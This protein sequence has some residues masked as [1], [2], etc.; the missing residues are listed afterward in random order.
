VQAGTQFSVTA[1][2]MDGAGG[3][4]T[5]LP[6]NAF[7]LSGFT[8]DAPTVTGSTLSS[9]C[10]APGLI[11]QNPQSLMLE[12]DNTSVVSEAITLVPGD[13]DA[14]QSSFSLNPDAS[15]PMT[16]IGADGSNTISATFTGRDRFGNPAASAS[17]TILAA[18]GRVNGSA[19]TSVT[20]NGTGQATV[21][22]RTP[23][24]FNALGDTLTAQFGGTDVATASIALKPAIT[25][26]TIVASDGMTSRT[27][28]DNPAQGIPV[29][30]TLS[31]G[32]GFV[33]GINVGFNVISG[34][35]MLGAVT[36]AGNGVYNARLFSTVAGD[37]T[38]GVQ[39][40]ITGGNLES[41]AGVTANFSFTPEDTIHV[42]NTQNSIVAPVAI[43]ATQSD[44][45]SVTP[46][47]RFDNTTTNATAVAMT[48]TLGGSRGTLGT[49]VKNAD[50]S[51]TANY[52]ANLVGNIQIT[53]RA[54]SV[55]SSN[56]LIDTLAI[57]LV[58]AVATVTVT[59]QEQF[60][61]SSGTNLITVVIRDNQN[62]VIPGDL[63][64]FITVSPSNGITGAVTKVG[65][66]YQTTYT[67][68][69][70]GT[71]VTVTATV[72]QGMAAPVSGNVTFNVADTTDFNYTVGADAK[73]IDIIAMVDNSGDFTANLNLIR[74]RMLDVI[75]EVNRDAT[76]DWRLSIA[77]L[78]YWPNYSNGY[79]LPDASG[80]QF[81]DRN[82]VDKSGWVNAVLGSVNA[83]S[84]IEDPTMVMEAV[85]DEFTKV[86]GLNN[87]V[88]R[89]NSHKFFISMTD[90]APLSTR[91]DTVPK[92]ATHIRDVILP[93]HPLKYDNTRTIT[94]GAIV[95]AGAMADH[96]LLADET[97]GGFVVQLD[98]ANIG[99]GLSITGQQIYQNNNRVYF[100]ERVVRVLSVTLNGV[101][102][103]GWTLDS[104]GMFIE[105]PA[106]LGTGDLMARTITAASVQ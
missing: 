105:F 83:L 44:S 80:A 17:V 98:T 29:R 3:D 18:M 27:V 78:T 20:L 81:I 47:D 85:M 97:N 64:S 34:N 5:G 39:V 10:T 41:V 100:S 24:T 8:C 33:D 30:V 40:G 7:T 101:V 22:Y 25:S 50:G 38:L 45:I 59:A 55:L 76:V 35:A 4:V 92:M 95:A 82:T 77:T 61:P 79:L 91:F 16:A 32:G 28:T 89:T 73:T 104:S 14:G 106:G 94:Y 1:A 75:A 58:P 2:L 96:Q 72:D 103:S 67:A 90:S 6:G 69:N 102:Q 37:V 9:N 62:Q 74:Q 93:M 60:V 12:F 53:I 54:T 23:N 68:P 99:N 36:A 26:A 87:N 65:N 70:G 66:D 43:F 56:V 86:N 84:P 21:T 63:T 48:V 31:D 11:S 42:V 49:P 15:T 71:G 57:T 51:F 46:K 13:P 52:T 19:S 88:L